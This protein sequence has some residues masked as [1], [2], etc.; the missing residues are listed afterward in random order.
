MRLKF[1]GVSA[2]KNMSL[3]NKKLYVKGSG[4]EKYHQFSCFTSFPNFQRIILRIS[5]A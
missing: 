5:S 1:S 4:R 3:A 2:E